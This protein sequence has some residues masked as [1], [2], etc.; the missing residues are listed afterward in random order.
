MMT[1]D[2][3]QDIPSLSSFPS[4]RHLQVLLCQDPTMTNRNLNRAKHSPRTLI[5]LPKHTLPRDWEIMLLH[6][7]ILARLDALRIRIIF[8]RYE[9]IMGRAEGWARN[10]D[11]A[12][13]ALDTYRRIR[14]VIAVRVG[15]DAEI[16]ERNTMGS[17]LAPR[18]GWKC[19]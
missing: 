3:S 11:L 8:R 17:L 1:I 7:G 19:E 6:L 10:L 15:G 9:S 18:R 5:R 12:F 2:S 4:L 14:S 16:R 13:S